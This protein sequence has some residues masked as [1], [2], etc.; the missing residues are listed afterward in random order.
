MLLSIAER[1]GDSATV[2]CNSDGDVMT[3]SLERSL[4]SLSLQQ[5]STTSLSS[6]SSSSTSTSGLVSLSKGHWGSQSHKR[7]L[8][9]LAYDEDGEGCGMDGSTSLSSSRRHASSC[10]NEGTSRQ[11]DKW[12]H[13]NPNKRLR[14]HQSYNAATTPS[15][16]DASSCSWGF[17]VSH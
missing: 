6:T 15:G 10:W 2:N 7:D 9:T 12:S 1:D 14:R 17:F 13:P 5:S 4:N 8:F 11:H 16:S 3:V